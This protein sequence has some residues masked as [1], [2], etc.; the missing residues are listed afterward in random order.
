LSATSP[1]S[2][3]NKIYLIA[4]EVSG[5][6]HGGKLVSALKR[7]DD[8]AQFF[9]VGGSNMKAQGQMQVID[10]KSF[11]IMG[12]WEVLTKI[13]Q[14]KRLFQLVKQDILDK[15]P[16]KVV[17]IDYGGFN[18]RMA[19]FCKAHAIETH[20]YILPKVWAWNE[21][22]VYKLVKYVDH[23]YAI[24]PFEEAYF[25]KFGLNCTYVGNPV[26]DSVSDYLK[27]V[28]GIEKNAEESYIA[29]LP[30]SRDQE[31]K[32]ILPSMLEAATLKPEASFVIALQADNQILK[33]MDIPSNVKIIVGKTYEVVRG[34]DCALVTS[35][36]ANLEAALLNIPQIVCYKA[37]PLSYAIGKRVVKIKYISPVNLILDRALVPEVLQNDLNGLHLSCLLD[38]LQQSQNRA[39]ILAGYMEL[40]V[41]LGNQRVDEHVAQL[42]LTK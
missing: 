18:L 6:L 3:S 30:G 9:G 23:A 1:T 22:R 35:G 10:I 40:S 29:L 24:F 28:E 14:I 39:R 36:T 21:K 37:N 41:L 2:K 7:L 27:R 15:Q 33:S 38:D 31:L 5:D 11:S 20:F 32:R 8:A 12:F 16:N 19:K 17:L 42:I 13:F 26:N 34:A 4:G 25:Q